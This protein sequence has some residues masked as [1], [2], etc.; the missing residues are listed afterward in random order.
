MIYTLINKHGCFKCAPY[1]KA[2]ELIESGVYID[3]TQYKPNDVRLVISR[4][5]SLEHNV[6]NKPKK[7]T[8]STA[9][10]KLELSKNNNSP[11]KGIVNLKRDIPIR[12]KR[13]A[14]KSRNSKSDN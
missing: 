3:I 13:N 1:E 12:R 9:K 8:K 11:F 2:Y 6:V 5:D 10:R 4:P 7:T 14:S